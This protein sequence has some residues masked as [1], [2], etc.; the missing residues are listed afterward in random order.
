MRGGVMAG[1]RLLC[2]IAAQLL[3]VDGAAVLTRGKADASALLYATD[4]V[5]ARLDDLEFVSGEGPCLEAYWNHCLVLEPDLAGGAATARW[6]W[7]APE[8]VAVNARAV[9]AFP[10][11]A[12]QVQFGVFWL[13]RRAAGGLIGRDLN[14]AHGLAQSAAALVLADVAEHSAEQLDAH[15]L[16][17]AYGRVEIDQAL[18]SIAG[19]RHSDI[20]EARVLL[21]STAFAQNRSSRAVAKDVLARRL[22]YP[23]D[24]PRSR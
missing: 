9:F 13:Y 11:Q 6:P 17:S 15:F 21:R 14:A 4:P 1:A 10:L 20:E 8:A 16:G 12:G 2:D 3:S 18:G 22:T 19:Q 5:I 24:P 23:P 7:F